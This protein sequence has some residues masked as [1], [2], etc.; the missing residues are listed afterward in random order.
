[1]SNILLEVDNIGHVYQTPKLQKE[2][3]KYVSFQIEEGEFVS[4]VGPSGCG[5]LTLLSIIAGMEHPTFGEV[6][7]GGRRVNGPTEEI[8]YMPQKDHLFSWRNIRSNI[9]LGLE[10]Q[11]KGPEYYP[12]PAS[13]HAWKGRKIIRRCSDS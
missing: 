9:T 11:K 12:R 2:A 8:G 3:L 13:I 6:R 4:L 1:M 5:K 7:L 10:I